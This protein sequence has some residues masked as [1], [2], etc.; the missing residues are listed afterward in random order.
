MNKI[1][2]I[3][4]VA[5]IAC[6][7]QA[8]VWD[9]FVN[10]GGDAGDLPSIAQMTD[11]VGPLSS[12]TA[13]HTASDVDLFAIKI[14]DPARFVAQVSGTLDSQIW[15]FTMSGL[16]VAHNDDFG[17]GVTSRV[18]GEDI[19]TTGVHTGAT[20]SSLLT[21]GECYLI[22][23][24]RYN[25]DAR[26]ENNLA[27]FAGSPF[28]GIH[29][30]VA[31]AGTLTAWAGTTS[32]VGN[33]SILLEGVEYCIPTPGALALMGMGGLVAARRRRA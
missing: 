32:S 13:N 3:V 30:A 26:D 1:L 21:A 8:Q 4:A 20:I 17:G 27:M 10:G 25:R 33:Y 24:S 11:G 14:V 15:L 9:E 31:G 5:G 18:R 28:S 16:A 7:A 22:G 19:F 23:V 2:S 29:S 12:I 6:A